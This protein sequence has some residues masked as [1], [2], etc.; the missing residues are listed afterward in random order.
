MKKIFLLFGFITFATLLTNAQEVAD[1]GNGRDKIK[2]LEI[3]YLTRQL[4]LS[5][6]EAERFWPLFNKYR[7]ELRFA[8][9]DRSINDELD[10]QQ[11]VL[12]IRKKYRKDFSNTLDEERGPKVYEAEDRFKTMVRKEMQQRM[13]MRQDGTAPQRKNK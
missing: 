6:S 1:S 12:D 10:R 9:K 3:G 5:T 13:K 7:K 11:K 4:Q 2:M 8:I